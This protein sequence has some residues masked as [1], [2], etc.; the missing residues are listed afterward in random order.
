MITIGRA[1]LTVSRTMAICILTCIGLTGCS[2]IYGKDAQ[3]LAQD[4]IDK[5]RNKG[6]SIQIGKNDKDP[7]NSRHITV[8][9]I[10][11]SCPATVEVRK[12]FDINMATDGFIKE[13]EESR[14]A[15]GVGP[16]AISISIPSIIKVGVGPQAMFISNPYIINVHDKNSSTVLMAAIK[17]ILPGAVIVECSPNSPGAKSVGQ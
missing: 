12:D 14:K 2:G 11:N 7:E 3:T 1:R 16:Q 6:L 4:F 17:E 5:L 9:I 13:C 10:A 8:Y 15:K